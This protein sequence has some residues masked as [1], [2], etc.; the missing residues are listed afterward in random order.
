MIDL[1]ITTFGRK[2]VFRQSLDSLLT[3]TS[4]D[5]FRLTVVIDGGKVKEYETTIF[6]CADTVLWHKE[7]L[8]LGPS[9]NSALGHIS[10]LNGYFD[11]NQK[12]FICMV[13]DDVEYTPGW[14]EKL[15]KVYGLFSRK[16]NLGFVSGHNAPE[17]ATSGEIMFGKDRLLLKPWIRATN[18]FAEKEYFLS[19]YPIPR[20]DPETGRQRGKPNN[21]MGSSCDWWFIRNHSNSVCKSGRINLVYPGLIKHIGFNKST[22]INRPLPEDK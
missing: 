1:F 3:C 12:N 14:L 15:I 19:M 7:N 8:G 6:D 13:Q 2:D 11:D 4:R 21:G 9:I 10:M 18:M 16:H 17:H 22:W 5:L 20:I